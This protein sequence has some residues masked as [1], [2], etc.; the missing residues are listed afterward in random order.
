MITRLGAF[1]P[2]PGIREAGRV[3]KNLYCDQLCSSRCPAFRIL[4]V[5]VLNDF[6]FFGIQ[7]RGSHRHNNQAESKLT[8][9]FHVSIRLG[10]F[11][12][13]LHW[14]LATIGTP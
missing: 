1:L 6:F 11:L 3:D 8:H 4:S 13:L 2:P 14:Q 9:R 7:A 10:S 5:S 12:T